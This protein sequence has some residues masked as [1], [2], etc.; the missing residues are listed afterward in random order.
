MK[1]ILIISLIAGALSATAAKTT[2]IATVSTSDSSKCE[3]TMVIGLATDAPTVGFEVV[4]SLF[5]TA[6]EA[7]ASIDYGITCFATVVTGPLIDGTTSGC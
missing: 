6:A 2:A 3:L 5:R 1:L 7:I 4:V